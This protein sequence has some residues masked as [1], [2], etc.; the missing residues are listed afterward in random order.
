MRNE[1]DK[2]SSVTHIKLA[3]WIQNELLP[4]GKF[5]PHNLWKGTSRQR[6]GKGAISKRI[7]LQKPSWGKT[8]LNIRYLYHE[9]IC[10]PNEQLLSQ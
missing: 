5:Q 6:S 2:T 10:K 7:P 1:T 8:K 9:N 4:F 3:T